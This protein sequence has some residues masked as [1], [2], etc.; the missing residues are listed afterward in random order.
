M[1]Q[2]FK[3]QLSMK[4]DRLPLKTFLLVNYNGLDH[5]LVE[6]YI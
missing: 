4:I 2:C 5:G 1:N 3:G 6:L